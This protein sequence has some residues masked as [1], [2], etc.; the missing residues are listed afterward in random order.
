MA[1]SGGA[2]SLVN[3]QRMNIEKALETRGERGGGREEDAG[4]VGNGACER[5]GRRPH[6]F[7]SSLPDDSLAGERNIF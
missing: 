3:E 5:R 1:K 7:G 2:C 6:Q 4:W